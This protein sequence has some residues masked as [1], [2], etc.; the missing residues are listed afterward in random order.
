MTD[1]DFAV[2]Q[3]PDRSG[4]TLRG[5]MRFESVQAYDRVLAPIREA[6]VAA[7]GRYQIDISGLVFLNSSGIR[8]LADLVLAARAG[9][10]S[11][12][13]VG[14]ATVPWQQKTFASLRKLYTG[15]EVRLE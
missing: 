11:L 9:G 2:E 12:V 13:I 8:A 6:L 1:L 15:L 3:Q 10:K 7:Q 14:A 4:A 5:V